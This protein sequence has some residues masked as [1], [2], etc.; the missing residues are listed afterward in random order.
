MQHIMP[1][2]SEVDVFEQKGYLIGKRIGK[3]TYATVHLADFVD[4]GTG[5]KFRLACKIFDKMKAPKDILR[6][7]FVRE[8]DILTKIKNPNI[9]Q[10]HSI[11][12]RGSRVFIF[13]KYASNGDLL[14][15]IKVNGTIPDTQAK[16]WFQQIASGLLY[17]HGLNIVH[18][19]LKCENI[20]LSENTM[21]KSQISDLQ[22]FVQTKKGMWYL[23]RRTVALPLTQRRKLLVV[24]RTTPKCL[25]F[26]LL[27]LY[28]I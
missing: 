27:E 3:G 22:G 20:L 24:Y 10:A 18:R 13:M 1:S 11:L 2:S 19:N 16:I 15:Y 5:K 21:Q 17:L 26:G 25:T 6:K 23:V 9:I 7:F 12:Q 8:L 28:Y 14:N 4:G